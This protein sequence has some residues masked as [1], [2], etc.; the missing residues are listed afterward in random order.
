M[1]RPVVLVVDDDAA[2]LAHVEGELTK[3]YGAD[4]EVLGHGSA[5]AALADLQQ[6]K[7]AA[8]PVALLL[9]DL[10]MRPTSGIELLVVAAELHPTARRGVLLDWVD[11]SRSKRNLVEASALA[12]I[13]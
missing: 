2:A 5:E 11:M 8:R 9:A 1:T 13:D 10:W 4:Y 6:L 12:Q 3:R 7:D